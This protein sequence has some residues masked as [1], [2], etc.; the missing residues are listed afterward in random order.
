MAPTAVK[1]WNIEVSH[2]GFSTCNDE[3]M[4]KCVDEIFFLA[5]DKHIACISTTEPSHIII[6][7]VGNPFFPKHLLASV[8]NASRK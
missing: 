8:R 3:I 2:L 6:C 5:K 4:V 7:G 1:D